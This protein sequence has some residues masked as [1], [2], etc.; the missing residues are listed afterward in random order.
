MDDFLHAPPTMLNDAIVM[1]EQLGSAGHVTL[2]R[3]V[4][5]RQ[6]GL[7]VVGRGTP[8]TDAALSHSKRPLIVLLGDDDDASS[9]PA[10]FPSWRRLKSWAGYGMIHAASADASTY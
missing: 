10:G 7:A 5:D 3:A 9:G 6:I 1:C 8:I 4:Q 2:F